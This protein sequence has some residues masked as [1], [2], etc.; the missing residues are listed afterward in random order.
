MGGEQHGQDGEQHSQDVPA[1]GGDSTV[2]RANGSVSARVRKWSLDHKIAAAGI[3]VAFIG[4]IAGPTIPVLLSSGGSASPGPSLVQNN[5]NNGGPGGAVQNPVQVGTNNGQVAPGGTII[6]NAPTASS[7]GLSSDPQAQIVQLTGSYSEQGFTT[8]IF[9]RNTSIVALYLKT[10]MHAA[11]L[12]QGT[13]AIFFGFEEVDQNDDP[14]QSGGA[15]ALVKTFQAA[16]FNVNEDLQDSYLMGELTGGTFPGMFD[17]PLTPK[18]Y[19]GGYQDGTFVGS[20]LFWIVQRALGWGPT[21]EDIQVIHYLV[22]QGADCKV[23]LSFLNDNG[24]NYSSGT[25]PYKELFPIIQGCAK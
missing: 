1:A 9:D 16:G 8:A 2:K 24:G 21:A 11:T 12:Y 5:T 4:A 14:I 18:G 13:S 10:G 25:G 7:A 15:V 20:L 6:N 19:T 22:S 3:V 17:T 23:T